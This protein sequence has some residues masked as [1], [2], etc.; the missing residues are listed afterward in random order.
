MISHACDSE[1]NRF[2]WFRMLATVKRIVFYGFALMR[3]EEKRFFS[4]SRAC[5]DEKIDYFPIPQP[6]TVIKNNF[7]RFPTRGKYKN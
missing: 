1:K 3:R 4:L 5:D 7:L 2:L 6:W